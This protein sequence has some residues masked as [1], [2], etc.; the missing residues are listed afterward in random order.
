[1]GE[2]KKGNAQIKTTVPRNSKKQK[3]IIKCN[4]CKQNIL[5]N[6]GWQQYTPFTILKNLMVV[7]LGSSVIGGFH[8]FIGIYVLGNLVK[9]DLSSRHLKVFRP[10]YIQQ[11]ATGKESLNRPNHATDQ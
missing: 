9:Y 2:Q 4:Y 11:Q 3:K 10:A 1:M 5:L 6:R 7:K 8:T